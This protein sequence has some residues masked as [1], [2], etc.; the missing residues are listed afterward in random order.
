[1]MTFGEQARNFPSDL[2]QTHRAMALKHAQPLE[3]INL[4]ATE[5]ARGTAA[6][7]SLLK[8]RH[9]QL[10]R[11]VLEAGHSLPEHHVPGEI[12]IQCLSGEADV[13][14]PSCTCRLVAGALVM[15]PA[16][17]PHG[18]QAHQD[19]VLLVTVMHP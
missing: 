5:E 19:T 4:H 9:L 7:S 14:T 3:G 17:E 12:T 8:T 1:M 18:V 6:S 10:L 11:V 15:L 2:R 16:A 13:A